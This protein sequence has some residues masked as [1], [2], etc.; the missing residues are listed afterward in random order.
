MWFGNI[1]I[2]ENLPTDQRQAVHRGMGHTPGTASRYYRNCKTV[3]DAIRV[4]KLIRLA[5]QCEEENEEVRFVASC[6]PR[7][8]APRNK[9]DQGKRTEKE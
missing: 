7:G 9:T 3:K 6:S 4:F 8:K 2:C 1:Q 5:N